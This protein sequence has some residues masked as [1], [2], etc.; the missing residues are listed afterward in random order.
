[1]VFTTRH[2]CKRTVWSER[3]TDVNFLDTNVENR[4]APNSPLGDFSCQIDRDD[5]ESVITEQLP[6]NKN[7]RACTRAWLRLLLQ[8]TIRIC[9]L[10]PGESRDFFFPTVLTFRD[11]IK[12]F[13]VAERYLVMRKVFIGVLRN[14]RGFIKVAMIFR[15]SCAV[16]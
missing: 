10:L 12:C 9:H 6:N 15:S 16:M 3:A 13:F 1:M 7:F 11:V 8:V 4:K 2:P 5:F 14:L